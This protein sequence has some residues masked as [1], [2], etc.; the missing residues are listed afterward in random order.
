[1]KGTHPMRNQIIVRPRQQLLESDINNIQSYT[2]SSFDEVL[3]KSIGT[4][5]RYAGFTTEKV[6][7]AEVSVSPGLLFLA[8][9]VHGKDFETNFD[10][11][12][13]LPVAAK[14]KAV[15]VAWGSTTETDVE[16]RNFRTDV[17][18]GA[19]EPQDVNMRRARVANVDIIY[20]QESASPQNPP[21]D[22][23]Y[24]HIATLTL[25]T[26]GVDEVEMNLDAQLKSNQEIYAILAALEAWK[27]LAE[28]L[29][30]TL[31]TDLAALASRLHQMSGIDVLDSLV[32][33]VALLKEKSGIDEDAVKYGADH[34]LIADEIDLEHAQSD[35]RVEEGLRFNFDGASEQSLA[36]FNPLDPLASVDVGTGQLLPKYNEHVRLAV[37]GFAG[38]VSMSQYASQE[39]DYKLRHVSR[40]R[41][42]YGDTTVKCTNSSWWRRGN[43]NPATHIFTLNNEQFVVLNPELAA[44]N[45]R[46]LRLRKFWVDTWTE[47]YWEAVVTDYSVNGAVT[48]QTALNAQGG[49]YLGTNIQLTQI[50][51]QGD[52]TMLL[53]ETDNG[54]PDLE[55]VI[56]SVTVAAADLNKYPNKTRFGVPPVYLERGKRY[57]RVFLTQGQ[58]RMAVADRNTYLEGTFFVGTDGAYLVGDLEKDILF[59]DIFARFVSSRTEIEFTTLSLGGGI[60]DIDLLAGML[61]PD[62]TTLAFEL[63]PEGQAV[64]KSLGDVDTNS[65]LYNKPAL[66]RMRAVFLGT[67]D[68]QP[69]IKLVGSRLR[70]TRSKDSFVSVSNVINLPA[71]STAITVTSYL[72]NFEEAKHDCVISI[73]DENDN[74]IAASVV[75]DSAADKGIRRKAT[76]ALGAATNSFKMKHVGGAVSDRE[77]YHLNE[78]VWHSY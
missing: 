1:M 24:V 29:L 35:C 67:T 4:K 63:Q 8:G 78:S 48:A 73:I 14:T 7:P 20:G 50:A 44:I 66:V 41:I 2:Q 55:K 10:L 52:I 45:H 69:M 32:Y 3:E 23:N 25:S 22:P 47:K 38:D 62:G 15:I 30:S 51:A 74:E 54:K 19:V 70:A 71:A 13:H 11:I 39:I 56:A 77:L 64:W 57:A 17:T 40:R 46:M 65:I 21:I 36:L 72:E 31:R 75:E 9:P 6:G 26:T 49:W 28:P 34:Y 33:D 43:Y 18:T 76:F 37:T 68:D 61:V 42:R 5:K 59:E 58:H 60:T 12:G 53:C 27:L 16:R